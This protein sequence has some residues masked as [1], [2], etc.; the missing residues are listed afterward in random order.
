[1]IL[2]FLVFVAATTE[3]WRKPSS[4]TD[5]IYFSQPTVE[6]MLSLR[7]PAHF[8]SLTVTSWLACGVCWNWTSYPFAFLMYGSQCGSPSPPTPHVPSGFNTP[9]ASARLS[10]SNYWYALTSDTSPEHVLK[11]YNFTIYCKPSSKSIPKF[12]RQISFKN[13]RICVD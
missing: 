10:T 2:N 8:I 3:M 7:R 6:S 13:F 1:M 5:C 4:C 9:V 12:W 11:S